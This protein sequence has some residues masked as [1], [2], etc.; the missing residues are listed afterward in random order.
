MLVLEKIKRES[1]NRT[2]G[3][4]R[5]VY[6]LYKKLIYS[7]W[8]D[9]T[10]FDTGEVFTDRAATV[11]EWPRLL[12]LFDFGFS[13]N[14]DLG[15][16]SL[17]RFGPP[18][19]LFLKRDNYILKIISYREISTFDVKRYHEIWYRRDIHR[20]ISYGPVHP[21]CFIE[22]YFIRFWIVK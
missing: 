9:I 19:P 7:R 12:G 1:E 21:K 8:N 22:W 18:P 14:W 20:Y 11:G 13:K 16:S 3:K 4:S 6:I 15:F 10:K 5:K 2:I 17:W